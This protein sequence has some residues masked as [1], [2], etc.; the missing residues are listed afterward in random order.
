MALDF[1]DSPAPGDTYTDG[2]TTWT[3][4]PP[5]W[6]A[7]SSVQGPPGPPGVCDCENDEGIYGYAPV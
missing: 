6:T 2:V 3:W 5:R 1:P 4:N 7:V